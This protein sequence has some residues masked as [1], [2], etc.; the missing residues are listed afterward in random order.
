MSLEHPHAAAWL[1]QRPFPQPNLRVEAPAGEQAPIGTPGQRMHRA[2]VTG[3]HLQMCA[4]VGLPEPDDGI[5][6]AAA[7]CAS[8]GGKGQALD[9][10]GMP[11]CPEQGTVLQVPQLDS[12]I[13]APGG[14][15]AFI[16]AEGEG[17]D[18]IEMRLPGQVQ[19]LPFLA[20]D[21]HFPPQP[22]WSRCC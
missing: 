14:Q 21:A 18:C 17:P 16:R 9:A 12:P 2:T 3:E 19:D 10:V 8:I 11:A 6:S 20:P 13:P 5:I 22:S 1:R 4:P 15:G 7:Q